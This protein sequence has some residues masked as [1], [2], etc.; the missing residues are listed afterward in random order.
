MSAPP[1]ARPARAR[2]IGPV[3]PILLL[4]ALAWAEIPADVEARIVQ[5]ALSSDA[6]NVTAPA[7]ALHDVGYLNADRARTVREYS[8]RRM[9]AVVTAEI[10]RNPALHREIVTTAI[11]AAPSLR[12]QI[13]AAASKDFPGFAGSFATLGPV[14]PLE[15]LPVIR[16]A[17]DPAPLPLPPSTK[18]REIR[19]ATGP[20]T[21]VRGDA[22][23]PPLAVDDPFAEATEPLVDDA[24]D[25]RTDETAIYDPLE[26]FNRGV[27]GF[28]DGVDFLILKPVASV[29][30][31]VLPEL[32]KRSVR[33]FFRNLR[34]PVRLTNDVLQ[35]EGGDA[36]NTTVRFLINST[37]GIG[38]LMEVAEDLG[39]EHR[40]ADFGQTMHSYGVGPGAYLVLPVLG[41]STLRDGVGTGVDVFFDP[42]TYLLDFYPERVAIAGVEGVVAREAL[43]DPLDELRAGSVDFYAALRS[44]Y[45]QNREIELRK[46][47]PADTSDADEAFE[48]F[49]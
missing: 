1:G 5:G 2:V 32:A 25:E 43:L 11:A 42:L 40:P 3:L 38:G 31:F 13:V 37:I 29:Y 46:G 24:D 33:N 14:A 8:A 9:A 34:S 44:L 12:P 17:L 19:S 36:A 16:P 10:V 35:L 30:G 48:A 41:P 23:A 27:L 15:R 6:F 21:V 20:T 26:G 22:A 7:P 4:P 47:R 45:F 39:F 28:N 49:E 18:S